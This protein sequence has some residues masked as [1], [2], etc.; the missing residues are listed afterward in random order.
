MVGDEATLV[1]LPPA[2]LKQTQLHGVKHTQYIPQ[3]R[4]HWMKC[5]SRYFYHN[6][7]AFKTPVYHCRLETLSEV[8][9][10][11]SDIQPILRWEGGHTTHDLIRLEYVSDSAHLNVVHKVAGPIP[12][13]RW[14]LPICHSVIL[15]SR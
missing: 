14:R 3:N 5:L 4:S 2:C 10:P 8:H 13:S 6:L 1:R 7:S 9:I 12:F 15:P 11:R